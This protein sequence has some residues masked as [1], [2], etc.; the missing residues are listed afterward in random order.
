M[1]TSTHTIQISPET[2]I[3]ELIDSLEKHQL[4]I[5]T[6]KFL[7]LNLPQITIIGQTENIENYK[8][9]YHYL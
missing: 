1:S 6:F 3:N 9:E 5:Q 7:N 8:T 4:E 2:T